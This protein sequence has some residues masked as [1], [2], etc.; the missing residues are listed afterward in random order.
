MRLCGLFL[1]SH[2]VFVQVIKFI[3][4]T[5]NSK[6]RRLKNTFH[7]WT[8]SRTLS[9]IRSATTYLHQFDKATITPPRI[10]IKP[11]RIDNTG[12]DLNGIDNTNSRNTFEKLDF[13]IF[14][15]KPLELCFIPFF[16]FL[17]ERNGS[18]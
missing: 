17:I 5:D 12:Y 2:Q 9:A 6:S 11:L 15:G 16:L 3:V 1:F 13:F 10:A 14:S 7:L 4:S 18:I 8:I